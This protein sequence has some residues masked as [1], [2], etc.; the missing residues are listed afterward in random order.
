MI[1]KVI[2]YLFLIMSVDCTNYLITLHQCLDRVYEER[3]CSQCTAVFLKLWSAGGFGRKII[4]K[5]SDKTNEKI[6]IHICAKTA[7]VG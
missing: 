4:A 2:L 7:F 1:K 3:C 6:S 5:M